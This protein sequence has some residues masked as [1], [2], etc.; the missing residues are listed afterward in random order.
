MNA[1]VVIKKFTKIYQL[2]YR[3][4]DYKENYFLWLHDFSIPPDNN[5]SERSLR[6]IKSKMKIS[7]QFQNI[8]NAEFHANIKTYIETCYRNDINPTD[9]LIQLM[10]DTPL[11]LDDVIKKG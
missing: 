5:L 7:G 2:D 4:L 1:H 9:A 3:I 8:Q 11:K 10:E 6:G